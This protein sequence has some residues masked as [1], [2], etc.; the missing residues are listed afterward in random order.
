MA[1]F[2]FT[3]GGGGAAGGYITLENSEL[4]A[5]QSSY[6]S[7]ALSAG[8]GSFNN[9]IT[10]TEAHDS[11]NTHM[12]LS[13]TAYVYYDTGLALSD[14]KTYKGV[15]LTVRIEC[16]MDS[17]FSGWSD[18]AGSFTM[19]PFAG[20]AE[21]ATA[22]IGMFSGITLNKGFSNRV[23]NLNT[24]R[25]GTDTQVSSTA[26]LSPSYDQAN[27]AY[28]TAQLTLTG[29]PIGTGATPTM[30]FVSGDFG[31]EFF[32]NSASRQR[33]TDTWSTKY[34]TAG[35]A[36]GNLIIGAMFSQ[37]DRGTPTTKTFDFDIKYLL[38]YIE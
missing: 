37:E 29:R 35:S 36:T 27:D 38:E 12:N 31:H 14:L 11:F 26:L 3:G 22:G 23:F 6:T 21:P 28:R 10:I 19:G 16:D 5:V 15:I 9:Q 13:T 25:F 32:D 18:I 24:G 17:T 8:A 7:F 2:I 4:T 34:H 33:G 30:G 20:N 1:R